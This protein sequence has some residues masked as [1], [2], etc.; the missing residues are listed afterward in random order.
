MTV[1]FTSLPRTDGILNWDEDPL[2]QG[3]DLSRVTDLVSFYAADNGLSLL[4][5]V[6][7]P[8]WA[9]EEN[10][11]RFGSSSKAEGYNECVWIWWAE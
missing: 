8:G 9:K 1:R 7:V 5:Q 2:Q 6:P 11:V 4:S 3:K 10:G